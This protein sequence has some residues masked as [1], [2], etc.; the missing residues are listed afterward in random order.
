VTPLPVPAQPLDSLDGAVIAAHE[1]GDGMRLARL[2]GEAADRFAEDGDIAA[3]CFFYT[4]AYIFALEQGA[5]E[6]ERYAAVLRRH[7]RL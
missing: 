3:A 5:P 2:Y 7:G 6:A 1:A 4:Q